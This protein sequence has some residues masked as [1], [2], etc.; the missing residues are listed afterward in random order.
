MLGKF[1]EF[2]V[3]APDIRSSLEFYQKLGFSEAT[4][5]ETRS[6]PYA[7]VTDGRLCI[8]L[9][10]R[11]FASPSLTFV[12]PNLL[13]HI[14]ELEVAA[15]EFEFRRLGD[16]VFNEVGFTDPSGHAINVIEART[17]SPAKRKPTDTSACGYFAEIG[18][19]SATLD[20]SKAFWE[21]CGFVAMDEPE[22]RLP[23]ISC[24]SDY[25]DVGLYD[26]VGLP[27]PTLI[28]EAADL[29]ATLATLERSGY[30]PAGN[31]SAALRGHAA[32]LSAP[33]GTRLLLMAGDSTGA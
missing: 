5:G 18:L 13:A 6:N 31:L 4:V 7:V 21:R 20:V 17:F 9:H 27:Y 33:E 12:Q 26:P 32:L 28:F 16:N 3:R 1:L 10:D 22:A 8:G 2:S 11:E 14:E 29:R 24:T 30:T 19:P 25:I 15:E 23:H